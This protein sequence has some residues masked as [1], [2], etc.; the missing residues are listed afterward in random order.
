MAAL[1]T[2]E[3]RRGN[4]QDPSSRSVLRRKCSEAMRQTYRG[5]P[6]SKC[7]FN[8]VTLQLY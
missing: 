2:N 5:I 4:T 7:D 3:L 1:E 8:K 6:M